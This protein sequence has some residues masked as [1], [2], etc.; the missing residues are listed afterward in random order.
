MKRGHRLAY[1]QAKVG[2]L[3]EGDRPH[4]LR[5]VGR[6]APVERTSPEGVRSHPLLPAI[7]TAYLRYEPFAATVPVS[8]FWT[9]ESYAHMGDLTL[10]W[11]PYLRG[12]FESQET[13][14]THSSLFDPPHVGCLADALRSTL[15]RLDPPATRRA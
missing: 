15:D 4:W 7:H 6:S 9:S 3:W 8:L 14:G 10:G 5:F 2:A 12:A 13:P 1:V 11:S